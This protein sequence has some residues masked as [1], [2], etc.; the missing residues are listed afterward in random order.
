[1]AAADKVFA[2]NPKH[3]QGRATQG[4]LALLRAQTLRD[5]D[6]RHAAAQASLTALGQ[7]I[8]S[9]PLLASSLTP[10]IAQAKAVATAP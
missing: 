8:A 7:A 10:L 2:I 6:A 4:S 1:M 5:S 3:A 9:D